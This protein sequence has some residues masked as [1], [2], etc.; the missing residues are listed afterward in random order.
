MITISDPASLACGG[1]FLG[2]LREFRQEKFGEGSMGTGAGA[3][4]QGLGGRA[5]PH[6]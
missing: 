1:H 2:A 6:H 4:S 5:T 3:S